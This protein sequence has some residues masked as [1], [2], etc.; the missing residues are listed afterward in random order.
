[1]R[2]APYNRRQPM[3]TPLRDVRN[4]VARCQPFEGNNIF[5]EKSDYAYAV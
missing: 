1:M 2:A 5:A 3:Y 4:L